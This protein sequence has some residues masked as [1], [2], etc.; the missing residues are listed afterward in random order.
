L[1][2]TRGSIVPA[3]RGT[4]AMRAQARRYGATLL[5]SVP[6]ER[7]DTIGDSAVV[8]VDGRDIRARR[9][10][11]CA[12]AWTRDL[13]LPLGV[14]LPLTVTLEQVTYFSP[15]D[16][17]RFRPGRMPLWIWM[18]DPAYYGF[19]C[20]GEPT[21]KAA[22]DCSGI[23]VSAD[24]RPFEADPDRLRELS[25]FMALRLPGSGPVV[26]SKT[27]LYTLPPD[28][29]F[30]LDAVPGH[31][32]VIV[33]LGAGHGFKFAPTFG[34]LLSELAVFG[35]TSTDVRPFALDRDA[36]TRADYPVN[37]LV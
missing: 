18:D 29:D 10:I 20:Y 30:V 31:E 3:A 26:R 17:A 32:A 9:V 24:D 27:C 22:R 2:Q 16:P 36:L 6:V 35:Q 28:R 37:W 8:R 21:V 13:L 7:I 1:F 14:D 23:C 11:V 5:D 34:R 4:A 12:D 19:P 15:P 25:D 33:G